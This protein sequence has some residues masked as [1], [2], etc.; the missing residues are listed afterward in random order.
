[1]TWLETVEKS[2]PLYDLQGSKVGE[3][4]LPNLF[5][6][7][8]RKDIIRRVYISSLTKKLQPKGRDPMAGRRT[9]ASSFGINLGMARIPRV[10]G[11]GEGALAPNTVGG[12]LAFP[13]TPRKEL[14]ENVNRKEVR[15]ALIS[16]LSATSDLSSVRARGHKF[17]G[18]VLPIVIRD[19]FEGMRT[20]VEALE[21][22]EELGLK[23]DLNRAKDGIKIRAGKGKMRGRRY[24]CPKSI[25]VVIGKD[26]AP[27]R[28]S[29]RNVPGVDVVS[30]RVVGVI[31]L[32]PGGQ[33]GRLT[34]YTESAL[35]KLTQRLGGGLQ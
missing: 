10:S 5:S 29:L 11:S 34:V 26:D 14:A 3:V 31:H 24:V 1:M 21:V 33:P 6:F 7:P 30:A 16:A 23:E 32:A 15:L 12:R 18:D 13:P 35:S 22:L 19:D 2:V 8:V 25:L 27:L 20:T 9:P 28:R 4:K 17:S